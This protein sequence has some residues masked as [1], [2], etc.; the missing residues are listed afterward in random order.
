MKDD[1]DPLEELRN[2]TWYP[3]YHHYVQDFNFGLQDIILVRYEMKRVSMRYVDKVPI[4]TG[5]AAPDIQK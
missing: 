3:S 2:L 4:S 5:Q 1:W